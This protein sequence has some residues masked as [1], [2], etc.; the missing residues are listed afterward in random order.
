MKVI[1]F[2]KMTIAL[3][4]KDNETIEEVEDR[5]VEA[6]D[7]VGEGAVFSYVLKVEEYDD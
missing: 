4:M 7:S 3:P 6:V 2:D 1:V 5:I